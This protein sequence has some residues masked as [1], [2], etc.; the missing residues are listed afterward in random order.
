M[1][2]ILSRFPSSVTRYMLGKSTNTSCCCLG[3]SEKPRNR[4]SETRVRFAPSTAIL[5]Q[6]EMTQ[7][8]CPGCWPRPASPLHPGSHPLLLVQPFISSSHSLLQQDPPP[9]F[10]ASF[11][12][13]NTPFIPHSPPARCHLEFGGQLPSTLTISHFHHVYLYAPRFHLV[14]RA[15]SACTQGNMEVLGVGTPRVT[16]GQ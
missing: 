6:S 13:V 14:T 8:S 12:S 7:R 4:N 9:P 5:N 16:F 15:G 10:A 3:S 2:R 11:P 1:A